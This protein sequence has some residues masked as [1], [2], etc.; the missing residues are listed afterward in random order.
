MTDAAD[1][2]AEIFG[3]NERA[4]QRGQIVHFQMGLFQYSDTV[5]GEL[6]ERVIADKCVYPILPV[7]ALAHDTE[8]LYSYPVAKEQIP[9]A[10]RDKIYPGHLAGKTPEEI[11]QIIH[12][13]YIG[14]DWV[15]QPLF[16]PGFSDDEAW[17]LDTTGLVENDENY[18]F[19]T[20]DDWGTD[21]SITRLLRILRKYNAKATFFVRTQ[22]VPINPNLLR[23]IA[24]EGHTIA[25]H[26]CH[27]LPLSHD[28]N[29]KGF[30]YVEITDEEAV[31]HFGEV[32]GHDEILKYKPPEISKTEI[33][34]L[35]QDGVTVPGAV[36]ESRVSTVIK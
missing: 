4:L 23:G 24:A 20:F 19:L 6:V 18:V 33:K 9:D 16:F 8:H 30:R 22:Y 28:S 35:I 32:S 12:D 25:S 2:M 26:T 36:I 10:V 11:S 31:R 7:D 1:V 15:N 14:S 13:G 27:Q 29:G 3:P 21:V 17:K 34:K 5:L